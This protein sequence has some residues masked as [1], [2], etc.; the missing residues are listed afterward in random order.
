[1]TE[2]R[3]GLLVLLQTSIPTA[4]SICERLNDQDVHAEVIDRPSSLALALAFGTYRVRVGVPAEQLETAR[5]LLDSWEPE[6]KA[7]VDALA[8]KVYGQLFGALI[9]GVLLYVG[10]YLYA[11]DPAL[12]MLA[13]ALVV[14]FLAFLALSFLERWRNA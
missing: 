14:M 11:G 13:P 8:R 5:R 10:L 3:K 9:P 2:E 4:E 7:N 1:M 12:W 6:T